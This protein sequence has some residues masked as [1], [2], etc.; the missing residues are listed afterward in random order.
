[1]TKK[2]AISLPDDLFRKIERERKRSGL[3]RSS[4]I[5]EAVG[6]YLTRNDEA[7]K[8]KAYFDGYERIPDTDEDFEGIA[9]YNEARLREG[10]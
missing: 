9:K 6:D 8:V 4:W 5:Q 10:R 1:V 2:T 3:D 7:A